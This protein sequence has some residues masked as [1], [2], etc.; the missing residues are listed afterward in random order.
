MVREFKVGDRV[1]YSCD[2]NVER[3][4]I[5]EVLDDKYWYTPVEKGMQYDAYYWEDL[6]LDTEEVVREFKVGDRV[7]WNNMS[8][9]RCGE[10]TSI[11]SGDHPI[12]VTFDDEKHS[13]TK[14][15]KYYA[16]YKPVLSHVNMED[17]TED[18]EFKVGDIVGFAGL[19]GEVVD[20][21]YH[22]E[23]PLL[24][25]LNN[26]VGDVESFT[27]KGMLEV[28]H[29]I[30]LLNFVSRPVKDEELIVKRSELEFQLLRR[31]FGRIDIAKITAIFEEL[32]CKEKEI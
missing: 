25:K 1:I 22:M 21:Y 32:G 27:L 19:E 20:V 29:K 2:G 6:D 4:T 9:V 31:N 17:N 5:K 15:G 14:D 10:V 3:F 12:M 18:F 7:K 23:Y 26:A 16:H 11:D 30:P 8:V 24:V 13:F 28:Y